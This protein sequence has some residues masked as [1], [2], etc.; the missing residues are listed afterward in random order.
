M[1]VDHW[2]CYLLCRT[3]YEADV[4][5]V[6]GLMGGAFHTWRQQDASKK[7]SKNNNNRIKP[8]PETANSRTKP[9]TE[10]AQ[11]IPN[12]SLPKDT[13]ASVSPVSNKAEANG[14]KKTKRK[15]KSIKDEI[16]QEQYENEA[17][18]SDMSPTCLQQGYTDCWPKVSWCTLIFLSISLQCTKST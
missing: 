12:E 3:P 18:L 14:L 4:V 2:F 16:V 11:Q 7:N 6:H 10:V 5:F 15:D 8:S 17:E 13:H 9:R 1:N